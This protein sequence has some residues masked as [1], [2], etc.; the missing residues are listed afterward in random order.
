MKG[1]GKDS[2]EVVGPEKLF[3]GPLASTCTQE[4]AVQGLWGQHKQLPQVF[5][6]SVQ[7][8]GQ[9]WDVAGG[10]AASVMEWV[11]GFIIHG[12]DHSSKGAK[13]AFSTGRWLRGGV[14]EL[15]GKD[16]TLAAMVEVQGSI[17]CADYC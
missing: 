5:L 11:K 1:V 16:A 12:F 13:N 7:E 9:G 17:C 15:A 2:E 4:P 10:W 14:V 3:T 8:Q 6:D